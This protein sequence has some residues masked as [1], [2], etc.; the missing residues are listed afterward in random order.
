MS[1]DVIASLLTGLAAVIT[2]MGAVL[3]GIRKRD[4]SI[5]DKAITDLKDQLESCR[6]DVTT[7]R[8]Q[9]E[10]QRL[11]AEKAEV[12]S[13]VQRMWGSYWRQLADLWYGIASSERHAFNNLNHKLRILTGDE[14]AHP[15]RPDLPPFEAIKDK[16][17]KLPW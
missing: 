14:Q 12:A 6:R 1:S 13:D 17:E 16:P 15:P 2:A 3:M 9:T 4:D 11:R 10:Y 7:E 5:D 8:Q